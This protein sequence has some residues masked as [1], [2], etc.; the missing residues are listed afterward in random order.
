MEDCKG[1]IKVDNRAF[2]RGLWGRKRG[3]LLCTWRRTV[4]EEEM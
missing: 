3:R 2:G 1:R 4:E